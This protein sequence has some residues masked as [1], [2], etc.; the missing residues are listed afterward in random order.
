MS[1]RNGPYKDG[2]K[3]A[4][5]TDEVLADDAKGHPVPTTHRMAMESYWMCGRQVWSLRSWL[6]GKG[7]CLMNNTTRC[8]SEAWDTHYSSQE[9]PCEVCGRWAE[10]TGC[11]CPECHWCGE[12]GNPKCRIIGGAGCW[13]ELRLD[14]VD[15]YYAEREAETL[16]EDEVNALTDL[17]EQKAED[18]RG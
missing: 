3:Y 11:A 18:G 13:S 5:K 17:A 15:K 16:S 1:Y 8:P 12:Q 4:F 14:N 9:A 10:G 2:T 7:V 6:T